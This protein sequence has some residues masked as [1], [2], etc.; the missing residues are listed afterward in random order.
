MLVTPIL[1]MRFKMRKQGEKLNKG[2]SGL[3]LILALLA[4]LALVL[5]LSGKSNTNTWYGTDAV[6]ISKLRGNN[7]AWVTP[8]AQPFVSTN[9]R[10]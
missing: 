9:E 6:T 10:T 7:N 1:R 5:V 4:L 8:D 3:Y 2:K